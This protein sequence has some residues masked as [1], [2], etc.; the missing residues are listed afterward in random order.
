MSKIAQRKEIEPASVIQKFTLNCFIIKL[1][2]EITH[3]RPDVIN[4]HDVRIMLEYVPLADLSS[5]GQTL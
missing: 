3:A 2:H 4:F 5:Q 1:G